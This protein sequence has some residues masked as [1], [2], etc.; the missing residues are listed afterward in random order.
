MRISDAE[1]AAT[2]PLMLVPSFNWTVAC[3]PAS[4][5]LGELHAEAIRS[6]TIAETTLIVLLQPGNAHLACAV[7]AAAAERGRE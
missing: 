1:D 5:E 7:V 4:D 2:V 6:T 3:G